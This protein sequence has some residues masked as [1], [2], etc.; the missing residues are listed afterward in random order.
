VPA[1]EKYASV[2]AEDW[3]VE[4]DVEDHDALRRALDRLRERGVA[5]EAR[6]RLGD[7]VTISVDPERIFAYTE[8]R[9]GAQEAARVLMELAES[10]HLE[11]RAT[12]AQWRADEERWD[13]V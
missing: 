12:I 1:D 3:R 6:H 8:T 9:E 10:H 7:D 13:P 2:M 4:L 5:R 11:V